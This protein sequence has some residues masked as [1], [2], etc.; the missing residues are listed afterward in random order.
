[1]SVVKLMG[2]VELARR[3]RVNEKTMRAW[4][5]SRDVP[6]PCAVLERQGAPDVK[7]WRVHRF[8]EWREWLRVHKATRD[9]RK[10]RTRR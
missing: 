9:S 4:I 2:S 8:P 5:N 10:V 7:Y 6:E 3:L 1:M